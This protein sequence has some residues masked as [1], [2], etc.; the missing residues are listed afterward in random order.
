MTIFAKIGALLVGLAG[1]SAVRGLAMKYFLKAIIITVVPLAVMIAFNLVLETLIGWVIERIAE[2]DTSG[3]PT[4]VT[5]S[6]TAGWLFCELG[7]DVAFGA[8]L[9]AASVRMLLRS[10]PFLHL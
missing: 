8:I 10:I 4:T 2:V 9:S 6:G 5:L 1:N 7:L 3:V